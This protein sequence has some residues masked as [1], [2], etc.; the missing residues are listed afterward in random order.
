MTGPAA[1]RYLLATV[2]IVTAAYCVT[3]L[4]AARLGRRPTAPDADIV[5]VVMGVAM[6]G[7]LVPRLSWL[8]DGAW[9]VVFGVATGWFGWQ[10][11]L[12]LRGCGRGRSH[13]LAG[14][15]V[16]AAHQAPH[17]LASGAMLYM[18]LAVSPGTAGA[19]GPAMAGSA[20]MG[21]Q[22]AGAIRFPLVAFIFAFA[23]L[24]Y[25]VWVTDR[26]P[27]LAPVSALRQAGGWPEADPQPRA[28][29]VSPRLA[30]CCEIVMG[31]V[32]G[33]MLIVLL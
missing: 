26:L 33:Y 6:A 14:S 10:T 13:G 22:S 20:V 27:A 1:L 16:R 8:P 17:L 3:R 15:G 5:H 12:S 9:E 28:V 19:A 25:V 31:A 24:G 21:G 4:L 23:L 32:M 30:A 2:M 11:L 18:F 7:M 29:P